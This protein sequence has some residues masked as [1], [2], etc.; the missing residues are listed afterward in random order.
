MSYSKTLMAAAITLL[1]TE[2]IANQVGVGSNHAGR[3]SCKKGFQQRKPCFIWAVV[4]HTLCRE[5]C[6]V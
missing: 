4:C 6:P 3:A 5:P 2:T 1:D